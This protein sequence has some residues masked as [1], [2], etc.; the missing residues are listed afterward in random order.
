MNSKITSRDKKKVGFPK[1]EQLNSPKT[2]ME[3]N[4]Q[5]TPEKENQDQLEM[6]ELSARSRESLANELND[7]LST[8]EKEVE[9]QRLQKL[10]VEREKQLEQAKEALQESEDK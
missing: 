5:G 9:I 7:G 8:Y 3:P 4:E 1:G 6:P 2:T 10:I